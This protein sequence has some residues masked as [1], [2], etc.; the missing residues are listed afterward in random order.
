METSRV[1]FFRTKECQL[2]NNCPFDEDQ[3]LNCFNYHKNCDRRRLPLIKNKDTGELTLTYIDVLCKNKCNK[4][5]CPYAHN[6]YEQN[7]HPMKIK[8]EACGDQQDCLFKI[9]YD[10]LQLAGTEDIES[11]I[12]G[13]NNQQNYKNYCY[14]YHKQQEV[15]YYAQLR[16]K[17]EPQY[18]KMKDELE[19][20]KFFVQGVENERVDDDKSQILNNSTF[21]YTAFINAQQDIDGSICKDFNFGE[22]SFSDINNNQAPFPFGITF[23]NNRQEDSFLQ[24]EIIE[25]NNDNQIETNQINKN[26]II[27]EEKQNNKISNHSKSQKSQN[28]KDKKSNNKYISKS[29][30]QNDQ[31]IKSKQELELFPNFVNKFQQLNNNKVN[32]QENNIS[33]QNQ[34]QPQKNSFV[35]DKSYQQLEEKILNQYKYKY[36]DT[37][38]EDEGQMLEFKDYNFKLSEDNM[39]DGIQNQDIMISKTIRTILGFLNSQGGFIIFGIEDNKK[40]KGSQMNVDQF[41]NSITPILAKCQPAV[42]E[43]HYKLHK[44]NLIGSKQSNIVVLQV[45]PQKHKL[46]FDNKQIYYRRTNASVITHEGIA[47]ANVMKENYKDLYKRKFESK[48]AKL[49]LIKKQEEED[50]KQK[51]I[52]QQKKDY[53]LLLKLLKKQNNIDSIIGIIDYKIMELENN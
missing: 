32:K 30:E 38:D 28:N 36:N 48:K 41:M 37:F 21:N 40:I 23:A 13:N 24:N 15:E 3:S 33:I 4:D 26:Q 46:F 52:D 29:P 11:L 25:I 5:D 35:Y 2:G 8:T 47:L 39:N 10:D 34:Q 20:H 17:L 7:Y 12:D 43:K 19:K 45:I 18:K 53:L 42:I 14:K 27:K 16:K 50:E 51:I 1:I 49:K 6:L 44:L 31:N 22:N 9:E